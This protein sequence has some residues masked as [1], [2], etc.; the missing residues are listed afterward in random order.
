MPNSLF[1]SLQDDYIH[2]EDD[3]DDNYI[4]PSDKGCSNK[5]R[6]LKFYI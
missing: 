5:I 3:T 6:K 2:P 4:D 1:V